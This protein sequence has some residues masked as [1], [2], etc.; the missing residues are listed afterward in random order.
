MKRAVSGLKTFSIALRV[1][2]LALVTTAASAESA[3]ESAR[4]SQ[5]EAFRDAEDALQLAARNRLGAAL[6]RASGLTDYPL[7]PYLERLRINRHL[8]I[9][10]RDIVETFLAR[11]DGQPVTYGLRSR[12]LKYLAKYGHKQAFLASYEAGMGAEITCHYLRYQLE[13]T[14]TPET[15]LHRVDSLWLSGKS[16][17]KA[18][19]PL[20]STWQKQG[21]MTPQKVLMRIEKAAKGGSIRLIPYLQRKLPDDWQYLAERWHNVRRN[22]AVVNRASLFPLNHPD[23]EADI[24]SWGIERL[25]WRDPD[26][27][28][29][30][31]YRWQR[32]SL[33]SQP[34]L[35]M[36]HRAIA[37]SL[38][39]DDS[40]Q[41]SEWLRRADVDGA[42]EDVK[43]WHLA[44]LLRQQRWKDVL[45]VIGRASTERRNDDAFIYWQARA[46]DKL[47]MP[48]QAGIL[49]DRLAKERHYY[50][51]MA[52]A[53]LSRPPTLDHAPVPVDDTAVERLRHHPAA[54]RAYEFFKMQRYLEARREWRFLM[55]QVS[56]EQIKYLAVLASE[57]GWHDQAI[58]SF[59]RSGYWNDVERRFPLAYQPEFADAAQQ[60]AVP[61]A[62]AMAIARRESSFMQD[63]VSPAGATGLMQLM[64]NTAR[65]VANTNVSRE[66]L[67]QPNQ[68][69]LYGVQY[70][71]YLMDK[72]KNNPVLVMASYNAGWQ[73]V[74]EWLPQD[75]AIPTDIWIETIP[76]HETRD[77]VKAVLAYRYIYESQLGESSRIFESL[78]DAMIPAA[79]QLERQ[80]S[81][82]AVNLTPQ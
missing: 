4:E 41:A 18:C 61:Q 42:D 47:G 67:F 58:V 72:M 23:H 34:Q 25:A 22:P 6:S 54:Q 73:R 52:S 35:L 68:N 60:F 17:P 13:D 27:A 76:Y 37:L 38:A 82:S 19:D 2:V 32:E 9:Q 1:V 75:A 80:G 46:F 59:A 8:T 15:L 36:M 16:Q 5:R 48:Q 11:Y 43:R 45:T 65:Y 50:G 69:L 39:I 40:P 29:K 30:A 31:Y 78:T 66:T 77:Y 81:V 7:Y 64:P 53:R 14:P 3:P 33:F 24:L 55:R 10:N 71:R 56:D 57:W 63:A 74:L 62:L 21:L 44:Y 28:I 49:Y 12:W 79:E 26:A 51:F 20:F 70:L